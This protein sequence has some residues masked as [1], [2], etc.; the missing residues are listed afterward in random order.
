MDSDQVVK[1]EYPSA[2]LIGVGAV[3]IKDDAVVLVRRANPP[4]RGEW[5]IPGGL[6]TIGETLTAAVRREAL[7]ETGLE[8]EP[9]RLVELLERIFP[10][11]GG[12]IKY[13]YVLADYL[14]LVKGGR[15]RAGS[16]ASE[17]VFAH[18]DELALYSLASITLRI[19]T[20]VIDETHIMLE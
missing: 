3:I 2:P 11:D 6:V 17:A 10:D 14:C 13:H 9:V 1:R 15:L 5:S 4:S 19:I 16:D 12:K 18:K 8:V 20:K 7:E